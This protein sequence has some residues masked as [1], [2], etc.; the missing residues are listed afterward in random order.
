MA[1][2]MTYV[3]RNYKPKKVTFI[4]TLTGACIMALG[5]T[6]GGIFSNDDDLSA[7]VVEAG[8]RSFEPMWRLPINDEFRDVIKL[9]NAADIT[10][11][12]A[13]PY[14]GASQ[15]ACFLERF[16]EDERVWAHLDIAG[17]SIGLGQTDTTGFGAQVLIELIDQI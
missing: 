4:A 13:V 3:Q 6:T 15:A 14:G 8:K 5:K 11:A 1:D 16:V 17:P 9:K 10:N 12:S 2:S 7:K